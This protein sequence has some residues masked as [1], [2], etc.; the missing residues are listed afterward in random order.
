LK[1]KRAGLTL[2]Q[3]DRWFELL[4]KVIQDNDLANHPAQIFNCDESGK[5]SIFTLV[6]NSI[7]H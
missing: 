4:N 3:V 2:Q 6:M 1:K 5:N 7:I